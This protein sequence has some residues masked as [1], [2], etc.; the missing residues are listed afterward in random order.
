MADNLD[1]LFRLKAQNQ[2]SP[3]IHAAQSDVTKLQQS[4]GTNF[5]QMQRVATTALNQVTTSLT[6]VSA[7]VPIVGSVLSDL[8]SEMTGTSAATEGTA[9]AM[10][11]LAGPIAI[12]VVALTVEL[13]AVVKLTEG[14]YDLV[15]S[16]AEYQGKLKDLSQQTGVT[17][18]TFSAL[19]IAIRK[20]GGS[21]EGAAQPLIIF[22]T[23]LE[24]AQDSSSNAGKAFRLLGVDALD[25]ETALRQTLSALAAMPEGFEQTARARELF[26]RGGRFFLAL[27]K[28]TGGDIDEVTRRFKDM[29][30]VTAEQ[31]ALADEFN[32]K[33]IDL[34][35]QLRGLGT[36]AIPVVLDALKDLSKTLEENRDIFEFLQNEIKVVALT[37]TVP[38]RAALGIIKTELEKAQFVLNITAQYFERIKAAIEYIVGHP[39]TLPSL[40]GSSVP[41]TPTAPAAKP[42]DRTASLRKD[43]QDEIEA[44]QRLQGVLNFEF[45][46]RKQQAEDSI[47][48]AHREFEAGRLTRE[49]LLQATLLGNRKKAQAE[50]DS[51]QVERDIQ[52]RSIALAK[53]DIQKR[54]QISARIL[55]I[56]KQIADKRAEV[57]RN[58][59]DLTAK[60]RLEERRDVLTHQQA[61]LEIITQSGQIRIEKIQEQIRLEQVDRKTGLDAV[62]KIENDALQARGQLLK[63]ELELAGVGPDRQAVLDKIKAIEVDRTALERQQSERRKQLAREEAESKRQ[64]LTANLDALLQIEQIRGNARIATVEAQA[65]LRIRTEENAAKEILAI[66]LRLID[67]EIE[68]TKAKQSAAAGIVDP[69]QRRQVQAQI[70]NDLKLLNAQREAVQQ[71]GERTIE[72]GRQRDLKNEREYADDL[73]DIKERISEIERDAAE[74]V[75]RLMRLHFAR[76]RD[77]IK[78]Q[79]DLDLADEEARHQRVTLSI[80]RQQDEVEQRI[81][82]IQSHLKALKIGT[83]EEIEQYERLIEEL[84]KLKLKRDELKR[85]Q[86]AED[87]RSQTRKRRVTDEAQFEIAAP[88]AALRDTFDALGESLTNLAGKFADAIGAGEE[89]SAMSAQIAQQI[90]GALAGAF[91]QFANALGQTVAN[92]VLLGETGPA[93]MR[94]ILAQALASLAAEA[95]VQAIK[96]LALGFASLFFNPAESAAHFT[97][98]ALWAS[99][100]GVAAIAGRSVAGDLFKP[101]DTQGSQSSSSPQPLQTIT[102]GRNQPQTVNIHLTSDLG[103]LSKVITTTV[104]QN[105]GDGGEI[106]QVMDRDGRAR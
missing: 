39:I 30:G 87:N 78:A 37:I 69:S 55:E 101:K 27:L 36:K 89:F 48:L 86:D 56:D 99:I 49:G 79:R 60:S 42:D 70:V 66:R 28:E 26:G 94:K 50:V 21:T 67:D 11:G 83:T 59:A 57:V 62:E 18:E 12:A 98:A 24:E 5:G 85:Q 47:A 58:G 44:R 33:L 82:V 96:Q 19:D 65:A 77:I 10:A 9:A 43:I 64:I 53:D 72:D 71:E 52:L 51:L 95:A 100:G 93:V 25:T 46:K 14:I 92:W 15:K 23:K 45:A 63:K 88:D 90:G 35:V 104:V 80:K 3:A 32:D 16:A 29:G 20:V 4:F 75:I 106:R 22:Q 2:A 73:R 74:E 8:T 40:T 68:A 13:G 7:R 105:Y 97:A 34:E 76:R 84:E 17:V 81:R 41:P 54:D 103:E 91:D 61:L 1:L 31:A 6:N 102:S 38:L